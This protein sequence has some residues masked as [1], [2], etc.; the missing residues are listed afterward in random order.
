MLILLN[1]T[2]V[3]DPDPDLLRSPLIGRIQVGKNDPKNKEKVKKCIVC[4]AGCS[5]L[6]ARSFS[7]SLDDL[8]GGQRIIAIFDQTV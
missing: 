6:W 8:H 1:K 5:L 7:C 2:N 3:W 4:S